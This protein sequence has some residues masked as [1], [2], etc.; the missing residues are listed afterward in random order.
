MAFQT[1]LVKNSNCSSH[2]E[3]N[4]NLNYQIV[5]KLGVILFIASCGR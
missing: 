5:N 2:I 1:L 3:E 4:I